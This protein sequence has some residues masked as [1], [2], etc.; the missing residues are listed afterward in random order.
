VAASPLTLEAVLAAVV[1]GR[2]A[3]LVLSP[4]QKRALRDADGQAALDVVRHLLGAR[5]VIGAPERF[6]LTEQAFQAIACRLGHSLGQKR[7][8][9]LI[10]RL[11]S[12]RVLA[13]SGCYRQR[14]RHSS[15]RSGLN[16][17]LLR[18]GRRSRPP[19]RKRP[20]GSR[21]VVKRRN[22]VRWWQHPLFGDLLER[23]PPELPRRQAARMR[24]LDEVYQ[25]P[26]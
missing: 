21:P 1:R 23:P 4:E 11:R 20:V 2:V 13:D 8:R 3:Y 24:S 19:K 26:R 18:L 14:Y 5:D 7:C 9:F 15:A 22:R 16:V 6:P 10:R 17:S 25:S 12:E